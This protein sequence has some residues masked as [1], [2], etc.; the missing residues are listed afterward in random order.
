MLRDYA[1]ERDW[2]RDVPNTALWELGVEDSFEG[3][4]ML[5]SAL[6]AYRD[7]TKLIEKRVWKGQVGIL[8]P[9]VEELRSEIIGTLGDRLRVPFKVKMGD[10]ERTITEVSDLEIGHIAYQSG[11]SG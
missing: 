5:H 4:S 2:C 9:F 11:E 6:L 1:L 8:L 10:N 3:Q 7:E